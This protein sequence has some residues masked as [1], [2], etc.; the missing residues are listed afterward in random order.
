MYSQPLLLRLV[1]AK[2]LSD[3]EGSNQER[4]T[5]FLIVANKS[6]MRGKW[7]PPWSSDTVALWPLWKFRKDRKPC[8]TS[9][10][11]E[12]KPTSRFAKKGDVLRSTHIF[13]WR[14]TESGKTVHV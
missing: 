11:T 5:I 10:A 4:A 8:L 1:K 6:S 3:Q 12:N 9:V 7:S 13:T 14:V 2:D